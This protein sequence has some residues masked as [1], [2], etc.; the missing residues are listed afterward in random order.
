MMVLV[1]SV[2][3]T[4]VS[5]LILL[6]LKYARSKNTK[7]KDDFVL[8]ELTIIPQVSLNKVHPDPVGHRCEIHAEE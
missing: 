6:V 5:I 8:E 3:I 4:S 7:V 2:L 1:T